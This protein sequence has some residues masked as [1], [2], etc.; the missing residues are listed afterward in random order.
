MPAS[1]AGYHFFGDFRKCQK[2]WYWKY[3]KQLLPM[4]DTT[5]LSNGK[6]FH[7]AMAKYYEAIRDGQDSAHARFN[8][9][10]YLMDTPL[11]EEEKI[12]L[13]AAFTMYSL[14]YQ[15]DPWK[16]IAIE[17]D[18]EQL[19]TL[20]VKWN[21]YQRSV[22]V[23]LTGRVDLVVE[24]D[25]RIFIVDHKTTKWIVS[26]VAEAN[27]LSDQATGY[28]AL[29]NAAHPDRPAAGAI[30]NILKIENKGG[31]DPDK[32]LRRE[33]VYRHPDDITG[34]LL[35]IAETS[36]EIEQKLKGPH[37]R[38]VKDRNACFLYN[39]KCEYADLC[40][41]ADPGRL[42]GISYTKGEVTD[43]KL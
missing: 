1:N 35:D 39:S 31:G 32:N 41:G 27:A 23:Y 5:A 18:F 19:F 22:E 10:A 40:A 28:I 3:V 12:K 43:D 34:F 16:V 8:A 13:R 14:Q 25:N 6:V 11:P 20:R 38:F 42:I 15:Y 21:V 4:H 26:K 2:Y 36:K 33:I 17:E 7:E 9:V 30:Y 24:W 37:T 29:W